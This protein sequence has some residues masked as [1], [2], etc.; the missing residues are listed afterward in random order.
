MAV[1]S[2]ALMMYIATEVVKDVAVDLSV[3]QQGVARIQA[4]YAA[5]S[6]LEL[7]LLRIMLYKQA[8]AGLGD[9]LGANKNM[10]DPI[11]SFPFMWPPTAMGGKVTEVDKDMLKEA[12]GESLMKGQQYTAIIQPEGG[13]LDINDLGSDLKSLKAATIAQVLK[14]F[15]TEVQNNEAFA[16]KYGGTRFEEVVN[17]IADYIDADTESLNGGDESSPYRDIDEKDIQMPPNRPLRTL[18]ELH[19]VAGMNDDF[20][21]LLAPKVTVFGT[22]GI[23]VNYAEKDLLMA[24]DITMTDEI[25]GKIIQRRSDPKLGGPFKDDNDFFGFIQGYGVNVKSIKESKIPLLYDMEFN[26]RVTATGFASNV[27]REIIAVTY[28]YTNLAPRYA[29]LMTDQELLDKGINPQQQQAA[30]TPGAGANASGTQ[31]QNGQKKI[32][33]Q[34]SKG[35]P[36]VVYW[37]EN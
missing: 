8:M 6:G 1:F 34:A 33:I 29:Q 4:Y 27:K 32:K 37:E 19:Q 24:L 14:I 5:K 17:N 11:W 3:A 30:A 36:N 10:L 28:D 25:V 22:K 21:N 18:D 26:F 12:V 13:K 2:V 7:S 35:R 23:N 16:K 15:T 9:T 20:Y 31:Q